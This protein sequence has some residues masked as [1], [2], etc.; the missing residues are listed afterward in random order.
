MEQLDLESEKAKEVYA[1]FGLAMYQAQCLE[2]QL[3][4]LLTTKYGPDPQRMTRTQYNDLFESFFSKTLGTLISHLRKT[5]D[6][7]DNLELTL[8]EAL[9]K[10]NW[11]AHH[12]FWKRAGQFMT[13]RGRM[14]M[15]HELQVIADFFALLDEQLTEIT[16]EWAEKHKITEEVLQKRIERLLRSV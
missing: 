15:I 1:R 2:R 7:P 5:V 10:R 3:A 6:I 13:E 12:Y 16:R 8:T 14:S 11:L 9:N 4:I